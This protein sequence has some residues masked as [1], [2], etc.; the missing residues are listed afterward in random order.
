MPFVGPHN[1]V[2]INLLP[3]LRMLTSSNSKNGS[4]V[5][6]VKLLINMETTFLLDQSAPRVDKESTW[7]FSL[8][9]FVHRNTAAQSLPITTE[10]LLFHTKK[11]VLLQRTVFLV[12]KKLMTDT[13]TQKSLKYVRDHYVF[14]AYIGVL[15][16]S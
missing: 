2:S 13:D 10:E 16:C 11:R 15:I 3:L 4:N 12:R 8:M 6:R 5:R 14:V 9:N 1:V 7:E